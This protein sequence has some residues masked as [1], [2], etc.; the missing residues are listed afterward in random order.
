MLKQIL[1]IALLVA[2]FWLF[3]RFRQRQSPVKSDTRPYREMV[4]CAHCG[5]YIPRSEATDN[6]SRDYFCSEEHRLAGPETS[7]KGSD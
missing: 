6:R 7:D 5:V 4:R 2:G 3:R 1:L